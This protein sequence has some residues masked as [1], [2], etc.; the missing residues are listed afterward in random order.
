[1]AG[2]SIMGL[3]FSFLGWPKP[4]VER[5]AATLGAPGTALQNAAGAQVMAAVGFA[6]FL[7]VAYMIY[8]TAIKSEAAAET[9]T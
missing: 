2:G 1:V 9:A 6:L 4:W 7:G 8:R 5:L 3:A